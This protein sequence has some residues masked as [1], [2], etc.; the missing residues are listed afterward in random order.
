MQPAAHA[1][2]SAIVA[3]ER[4][5]RRVVDTTATEHD[6]N[7][8]RDHN[9]LEQHEQP[10][11]AVVDR[12][13]KPPPPVAAAAAAAAT[14]TASPPPKASSSERVEVRDAGSDDINGIWCPTT[15]RGRFGGFVIYRLEGGGGKE[16]L[17]RHKMHDDGWTI[18]GADGHVRC[19]FEGTSEAAPTHGWQIA[20][21]ES[22][23]PTVAVI[24]TPPVGRDE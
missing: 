22:P 21:G 11:V 9:T 12:Q 20:Q 5:A 24:A 2:P 18:T 1:A 10:P 8:N 19:R 14:T 4:Q 6:Q 7:R 23:C 15:E 17:Y 3:V 16:M 13:A